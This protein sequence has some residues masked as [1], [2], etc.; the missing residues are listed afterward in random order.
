M[1]RFVSLP[2]GTVFAQKPLQFSTPLQGSNLTTKDVVDILSV[3]EA[4]GKSESIG[5]LAGLAKENVY[6]PLKA[7]LT[8]KEQPKPD[9]TA[10]TAQAVAPPSAA[11]PASTQKPVE[12]GQPV[13]PDIPAKPQAPVIPPEVVANLPKVQPKAAETPTTPA[14]PP[15]AAQAPVVTPPSAPQKAPETPQIP[16]PTQP[17]VAPQTPAT[18]AT[19]PLGKG[20]IPKIGVAAGGLEIPQKFPVET[21]EERAFRQEAMRN[22]EAGAGIQGRIPE[23]APPA[24]TVDQ[25]A[26]ARVAAA[27][28]A[29]QPVQV[30]L[31]ES[32]KEPA[33]APAPTPP[34]PPPVYKLKEETNKVAGQLAAMAAGGASQREIQAY[35]EQYQKQGTL[36]SDYY[37]MIGALKAAKESLPQDSQERR[38]IFMEEET[39]RRK[40]KMAMEERGLKYDESQVPTLKAST[41]AQPKRGTQA[42][43]PQDVL[44]K[45]FA[46]GTEALTDAEKFAMLAGGPASARP[47]QVPP[48]AGKKTVSAEGVKV[49]DQEPKTPELKQ[50]ALEPN[51]PEVVVPPAPAAPVGGAVGGGRVTKQVV[52][53][54][55]SRTIP[56]VEAAQPG[57][58]QPGFDVDAQNVKQAGAMAAGAAAEKAAEQVARTQ[59]Q[60]EAGFRQSF[61]DLMKKFPAKG[62]QAPAGTKA[63]VER[64]LLAQGDPDFILKMVEEKIRADEEKSAVQIPDKV[65]YQ[66]L[67]SLARRAT[68]PADQAAVLG[69]FERAT[70]KPPPKTLVEMYNR[71]NE[72]R[73]IA[74]LEAA[75]PAR[76]AQDDP[77]TRQQKYAKAYRDVAD[78]ILKRQQ[79]ETSQAQEAL[80]TQKAFREES[81][82]A[83]GDVQADMANKLAQ[84]QARLESAGLSAEKARETR[85]LVELKKSAIAATVAAKAAEFDNRYNYKLATIAAGG[86]GGGKGKGMKIKPELEYRMK[87]GTYKE[88][89]DEQ[90]KVLAN[91][92]NQATRAKVIPVQIADLKRRRQ[93]AINQGPAFAPNVSAYD[94][95][96]AELEGE[97]ASL[98][99][100]TELANQ[101]D[102][103][104]QA[105]QDMENRRQ[106]LV[107]EMLGRK[108]AEAP[109]NPSVP[110]TRDSGGQPTSP[111]QRG[112][113]GKAP[114]TTT[115]G[116]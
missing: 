96:I 52:V 84:A 1:A 112:K 83:A 23:G 69:A 44:D 73:A 63:T 22:I 88:M 12:G 76:A 81:E 5:A 51:R 79:A 45:F 65:T 16:Q 43:V 62:A 53:E 89:I 50:K 29:E 67:L 108:P 36:V 61:D 107:D 75:F 34:A 35:I 60:P 19:S 90:R 92:Q 94:T 8:S 2:S 15:A 37:N 38:K 86:G 71:D 68:R 105:L 40:I 3:A 110:L 111:G 114:T 80:F 102:L 113:T 33:P 39:L 9:T 82:I 6:D 95:K 56:S 77:Y 64:D 21:P 57:V 109:A 28:Q 97:R 70:N 78:S 93:D 103:A 11:T 85:E 10:D 42:E 31:R 99:S 100:P 41:P 49:Q 116:K 14:T 46:G 104:K 18:E 7:A 32:P 13:K 17:P 106:G 55:G 20:I 74:M 4:V 26:A 24:P 98:L 27:R 58:A 72:T 115:K 66:Q 48:P 101:I 91:L 25:A 59:A 54:G 87:E 47:P 30:T